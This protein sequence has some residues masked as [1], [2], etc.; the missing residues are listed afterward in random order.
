MTQC[1]AFATAAQTVPDSW[2]ERL[3]RQLCSLPCNPALFRSE[4]LT[5]HSRAPDLKAV[6]KLASP[7]MRRARM[8][9]HSDHQFSPSWGSNVVPLLEFQGG[10]TRGHSGWEEEK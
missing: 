6:T 5:G 3:R 7:P 10:R 9:I 1:A 2:W 8:S 4:Q